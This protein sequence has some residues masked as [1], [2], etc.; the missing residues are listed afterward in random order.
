MPFLYFLKHFS[1]PKTLNL[2][3]TWRRG[4]IL[5]VTKIYYTVPLFIYAARISCL[6][7]CPAEK[8]LEP[9]TSR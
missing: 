5:D 4:L 3:A 8:D 9:T 6:E 1:T 2:H 7:I